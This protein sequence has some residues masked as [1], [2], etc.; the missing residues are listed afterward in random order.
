LW[1]ADCLASIATVASGSSA[2]CREEGAQKSAR[3]AR[4]KRN[5]SSLTSCVSVLCP[6]RHHGGRMRRAE[7]IRVGELTGAMP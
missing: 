1:T 2:A 5:F 7:A 6:I 4:L 3:T